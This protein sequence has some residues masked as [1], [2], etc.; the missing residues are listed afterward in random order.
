[1]VVCVTL[2]ECSPEDG[3][4]LLAQ[5]EQIFFDTAHTTSFKSEADRR[6][7]YQRWFGNYANTH[8]GAFLF[9]LDADGKVTGYLA[10]C[11]DSFSPAAKA[12]IG[13]IYYFTPSFCGALKN[14]PSHFHINVLPGQQGK[15]IGHLLAGR[16]AEV[17]A[18]AGSPGIHVVTGSSSRAVR[19]Y[20]ACGFELVVPYTGAD[21]GLA[22]LIRTTAAP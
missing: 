14:Y 22:I 2:G 12:I 16:F 11:P 7:F 13:D 8:S 10:G 17:C 15:G 4:R 19:F 5:A 9:A 3:S 18:A 1:M 21:P 6:T 20:K